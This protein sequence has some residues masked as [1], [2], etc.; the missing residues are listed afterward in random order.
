MSE[1]PK[2]NPPELTM[3]SGRV[4][5]AVWP[6]TIQ[7]DGKDIV[8]YDLKVV[9][10]YKDKDEKWHDTSIY[11]PQDMADLRLVASKLEERF[12]LKV[13]TSSNGDAREGE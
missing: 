4:Q 11:S 12:R 7:K 9:R 8:V 13:G 2:G 6:K 3:R 5:G 1:K 10:G